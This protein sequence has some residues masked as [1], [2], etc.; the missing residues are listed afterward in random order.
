MEGVCK[1]KFLT[2]YAVAGVMYGG[3]VEASNW[4]D[5]VFKVGP[6]QKVIGIHI[7]DVT[8]DGLGDKLQ[9]SFDDS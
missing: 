3:S 8:D 1:V 2:E 6:F 7:G 9:K 5:A 4:A